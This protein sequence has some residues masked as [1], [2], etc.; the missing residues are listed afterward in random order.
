MD[1][2]PDAFD[3]EVRL[4]SIDVIHHLAD[5]PKETMTYPLTKPSQVLTTSSMVGRLLGFADQHF[6][7]SFYISAVSPS[8]FSACGLAGLFPLAV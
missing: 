4:L 2:R 6:S 3:T 1:W 5:D 8:C 7:M